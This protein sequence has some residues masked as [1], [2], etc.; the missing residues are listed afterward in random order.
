ML[1]NPAD[2]SGRLHRRVTSGIAAAI[3]NQLQNAGEAEPFKDEDSEITPIEYRD[4]DFDQLLQDI[5]SFKTEVSALAMKGLQHTIANAVEARMKS[6]SLRDLE[7]L[8]KA[9]GLPAQADHAL[10]R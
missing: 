5:S 10:S 8:A 4:R 9:R 7:S 3:A 2:L 1:V 6:L